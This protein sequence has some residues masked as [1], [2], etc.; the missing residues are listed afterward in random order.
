MLSCLISP[1]IRCLYQ[2]ARLGHTVSVW[3]CQAGF[4]KALI[5]LGTWQWV[6]TVQ[7]KLALSFWEFGASF[8]LAYGGGEILKEFKIAVLLLF[9]YP[10]V[11]FRRIE[12][13]RKIL[14]LEIRRVFCVNTCPGFL[15]PLPVGTDLG[16]KRFTVAAAK[17]LR[18]CPTLVRPQR[19]QPTR[20]PHP[21]DSPGKNTGV[22]CHFLLQC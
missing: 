22:G 1:V 18:S 19:R 12:F 15:P 16:R 6:P 13:Y 14:K 4:I 9:Q 5:D 3:L 8:C 21:W 2:A 17:L 20:L 7:N 10:Y 11:Y